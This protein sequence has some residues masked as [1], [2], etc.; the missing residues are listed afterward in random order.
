MRALLLPAGCLLVAGA[1]QEK[2]K[3]GAACPSLCPEPGVTFTEVTLYPVDLDSTLVG[4]PPI[5]SETSLLLAQ[6]GAS[7]LIGGVIRYDSLLTA[8]PT[9][10]TTVRTVAGVDSAVMNITIAPRGLA[11]APVTFT[12]YDV[13]V[14]APDFDTASVRALFVPSRAFAS[15][16]LPIDSVKDTVAKTIRIQIPPA[17]ILGKIQ[18]SKRTRI[19]VLVTSDQPVQLLAGSTE[20]TGGAQL[21]Y[22]VRTIADAPTARDTSTIT[23][24]PRST[25][26]I[27]NGD[28][29]AAFTDY[30]VAIRSESSVPPDAFAIGGVP[31]A[32]AFLRFVLPKTITDSGTVVSAS[33]ML[34]QIPNQRAGAADS[35]TIIPRV[36]LASTLVDVGKSALLLTDPALLQAT[37]LKMLPSDAGVRRF[38]LATVIERQWKPDDPTKVQRALVLQSS[39]EAIGPQ[40]ILF[41]SR[42]A[43]I[44]T[45]RPR[46]RV[47]Y[48]PRTTFGLP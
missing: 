14:A 6:R 22:R 16:T 23:I 25:S 32:R 13:D 21:T 38:D 12:L 2:L 3:G 47:R 46:L 36:V 29:G 43:A 30:T 27:T 7:F 19:G 40:Q 10:G 9:N 28:L 8:L 45:L 39:A 20:G 34:T 37:A 1:C 26:S 31:A 11:T 44:D 33:L 42:E 17:Y 48:V 5:G 41:Y 18:S 35:V 4:Y 24:G 15:Q